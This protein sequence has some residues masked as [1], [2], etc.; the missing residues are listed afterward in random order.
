[1]Y[2]QF[3]I[4]EVGQEQDRHQPATKETEEEGGRK[5]HSLTSVRRIETVKE[6]RSANSVC[7]QGVL[8]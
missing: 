3:D 7:V 8:F 5:M 2:E 4:P 1:M 6:N